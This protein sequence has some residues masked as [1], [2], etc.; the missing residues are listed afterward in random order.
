MGLEITQIDNANLRII[1]EQADLNKDGILKGREELDIFGEASK[2]AIKQN[3]VSRDDFDAT[4]KVFSLKYP[5]G[6]EMLKSLAMQADDDKSGNLTKDE[7]TSFIESGKNATK[8]NQATKEELETATDG[9]YYKEQKKDKQI[10]TAKIIGTVL[11]GAVVAGL[12]LVGISRV[13]NQVLKRFVT[14]YRG[15]FRAQD[16]VTCAELGATGVATI[17]GG[18]AG[19]ILASKATKKMI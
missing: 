18:V 4:L 7:I 9:L 13:T 3:L 17:A 8:A 10:S 6:N 11:C 1:A 2:K 14:G 16:I 19:G 12:S 5:E 15:N